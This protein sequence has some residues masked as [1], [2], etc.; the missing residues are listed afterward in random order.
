MQV[1]YKFP[2]LVAFCNR[3]AIDSSIVY[4]IADTSLNMLK[5]SRFINSLKYYKYRNFDITLRL[6]PCLC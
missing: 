1:T 4:T 3:L 5:L 2:E 6:L